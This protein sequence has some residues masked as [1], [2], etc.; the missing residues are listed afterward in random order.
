MLGG[1]CVQEEIR[2]LVCPE[3]M[4]SRLFTEALEDNECLVVTGEG[5]QPLRTHTH[6]PAQTQRLP[7]LQGRSSLVVTMATALGL[8]GRAVSQTVQCEM[9]GGGDRRWWLPWTHCTSETRTP[10]S[11]L[12]GFP[13]P[14]ATL[15]YV[16]ITSSL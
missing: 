9:P 11:N 15:H 12:V 16:I 6:T 5:R 10:S 8:S 4:V 2:F 3:L 14:R 1:G 13:E 7:H